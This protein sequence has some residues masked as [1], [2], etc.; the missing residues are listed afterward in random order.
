MR[1]QFHTTRKNE[2]NVEILFSTSELKIEKKGK[3][4]LGTE[5]PPKNM[6]TL[7]LQ[8]KYLILHKSEQQH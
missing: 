4:L 6:K 1:K 2:K 3:E 5:I 8:S 7:H